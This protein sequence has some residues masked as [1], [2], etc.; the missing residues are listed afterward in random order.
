M[1]TRLILCA[2]ILTA[3]LAAGCA[4]KRAVTVDSH[5]TIVRLGDDVNGHIYLYDAKT[6]DWILTANK[7]TLPEGWFAGFYE[8]PPARNPV[9]SHWKSLI[10]ALWFTLLLAGLLWWYHRKKRR[11]Y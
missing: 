6:H 2:A 1:Q 10:S 7:M 4:T 3:A 8:V 11:G 5:S 9:V